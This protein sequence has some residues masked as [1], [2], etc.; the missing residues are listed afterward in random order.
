MI[1][2]F[3]GRDWTLDLD[4]I[5]YSQAKALK[6]QHGLTLIALQDGLKQADPDALGAL[7]WLMK[8]Q[9]GVAVDMNKVNF[10]IVQFGIALSD[11][12]DREEAEAA[13]VDPTEQP[14]ATPATT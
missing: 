13:E 10:K 5:D 14:E 6:R 11:A 4:E 12:S 3:E 9:S 2:N 1:V 7:Y 8:A